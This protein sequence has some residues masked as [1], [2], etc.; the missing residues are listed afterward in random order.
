MGLQAAFDLLLAS[1]SALKGLDALI[2]QSLAAAATSAKH[3]WTNGCLTTI[4][5]IDGERP[6]PSSRTVVLRRCDVAARTID[7]YTDVRSSKVNELESRGGAVCWLFYHPSTKIQLRLQG[8]AN[9]VNDKQA[10]AEWETV[11][12]RSRS[13]YLSVEP[14]GKAVVNPQPPST[15]DRFVEQEESERG[16]ENFRLIRTQVETVDWLY[17]RQGGH[18][19]ASLEY[20]GKESVQESWLVP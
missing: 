2:W 7:C 13:A 18:V 15:D 14:P 16:R 9:V 10:D 5:T 11:S 6:C 4:S 1:E 8:S 19:R 12:L 17:L 20:G 3:P